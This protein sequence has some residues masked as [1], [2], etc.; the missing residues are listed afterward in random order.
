FEIEDKLL[1]IVDI[2]G[3]KK[4]YIPASYVKQILEDAY[5]RKY[6]FGVNRILYD[7]A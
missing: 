7:L 2:K 3:K 4:L 1:Y 6:Y 5:N